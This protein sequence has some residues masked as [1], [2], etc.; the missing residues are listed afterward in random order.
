MQC[1]IDPS[2]QDYVRVNDSTPR[3]PANQPKSAIIRITGDSHQTHLFHMSPK[4]PAP[5]GIVCSS[6][7]ALRAAALSLAGPRFISVILLNLVA[8]DCGIN[9]R[10][11]IGC[12]AGSLM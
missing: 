9:V 1:T 10:I 11:S 2:V 8:S 3:E 6:Q 5:L 12:K 7:L 4:T